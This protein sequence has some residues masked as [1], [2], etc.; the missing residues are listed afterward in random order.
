M[1]TNIFIQLKKYIPI[2]F[3]AMLLM[4]CERELDDLQPATFPENPEVFIDGF[5][6]GLNYSAF[7]GSVPTA[8]DVD[9]D[10]TYNSS[11]ASMRFDVPNAGDP[12]GA[13]AG[14]VFSTEV[15]RDL[16][17]FNALTF[18]AK[19]SQAASL[20]LI[21]FG[22]DLGASTNQ[23]TISGLSVSTS[24]KKYIIPIP[25]PS[26]LTKERGM[27]FYS[28]GPEDGKGYS[29]WIDEMKFE[30]LGTIAHPQFG[31]LN[32]QNQVET[33]FV[34]VSKT[35]GG[36]TSSFNM[37]TGI[38]Q[39]INIAPSYFEFESSNPSIASVDASGKVSVTGGPGDATITASV[40]G[41]TVNGSLT[42]QSQGEYQHAP[43]PTHP[44]ENVISLFSNAYSN[45]PVNY[46]NGYWEPYQTTGSA[47]FEVAG[48]HVLH[49]TDFNFVGI[50]FSS[51]TI[52]AS[53]MSH[54]HFDIFIP[55]VLTS[56]A[57]LSIEVVDFG[58]DVSGTVTRTITPAQSQQWVSFDIPFSNFSG[59]N[60]RTNLAQIILVDVNNN[61]SNFYA[62]NIYF[63]TE[64]TVPSA[65]A[66]V[67]PTP[68]H[69]AAN[70]LSVFSDAY[71]QIPGTNVNPGWGQATVTSIVQVQGNNTLKMAGLNY[72][73]IELGSSQ[74]ASDMDFLHLDFWTANSTALSVFLISPGPVETGYS[75]TVPTSGWTSINIPLSSFSPVDLSDV[76]QLKFDGNGD[77][78]LDN[79]YFGKN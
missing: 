29:F 53:G 68:S 20:D 56:N 51:P 19:A 32:G 44:A 55:N 64:A 23:V 41:E 62:D 73:G 7:G 14:G 42:V 25:D 40:G 43:T 57:Q 16:S 75:L 8:F 47:D 12:E 45:A 17:G 5:S 37:P 70:V 27:F 24:W 78:Y 21:G 58:A 72:Q 10:V 65:P 31:I 2:G 9:N 76:I 30:N 59:L 71:T 3:V 22:N 69:S 61:I 79:I 18:W 67:A 38:N 50:E 66:T 46:Y 35:I 63:Y 13:Y 26:K 60:S 4:G 39:E 34:G 11:K 49:Y 15:A 6:A 33:A 36:L 52:D 54:L 74:N 1:N 28:V 77:I 48:D